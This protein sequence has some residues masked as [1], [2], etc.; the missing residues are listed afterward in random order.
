MSTNHMNSRKILLS[1]AI[2]LIASCSYSDQDPI[3]DNLRIGANGMLPS[4]ILDH[5]DAAVSVAGSSLSSVD[6]SGLAGTPDGLDL[7]RN[8]VTCALPADSSLVVHVGGSDGSSMR[9]SGL[10]GLAP[11]WVRRPMSVVERRWVSAC[12][13]AR[14]NALGESVSISVL[15]DSRALDASP[16]ESS[17]FPV[18]EGAFYG[19][20]FAP[21]VEQFACRGTGSSD[22]GGM[23]DRLCAVADPGRPGLTLCGFTLAGL[24][25]TAC[26]ESTAGMYSG[27][28]DGL[29]RGAGQVITVHVS[30]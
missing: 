1:L 13:L 19:D 14:S 7:L 12:L 21:V 17:D 27:C 30:P 24:C 28:L 2:A 15:G 9:I 25:A 8:L 4:V 29:G 5:H 6:L 18:E 16:V 20:V 10:I 22:A 11:S 23:R 3:Q 26:A